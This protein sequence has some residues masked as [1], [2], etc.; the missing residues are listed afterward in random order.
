MIKNLED[1]INKGDKLNAL[2][3]AAFATISITIC[4]SLFLLFY[5]MCG[6]AYVMAA[7]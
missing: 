1:K 7:N 6:L 3:Y 2:D 5:L 4:A